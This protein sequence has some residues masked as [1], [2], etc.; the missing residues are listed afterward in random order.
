MNQKGHIVN[1]ALLGI[2]LGYILQPSS[3][4]AMVRTIFEVSV[5]IILGALFPDVD[6]HFGTHRQT[7]H[8]LV[9]L[10]IFLVFPVYFANL[11]WVWLGVL[12]HYVLDF[13]GT[14]RGLALLYPWSRE[15]DF[16]LGVS[17]DSRYA[18]AMMLAITAF[19]L[20]VA[21]ALVHVFPGLVESVI[22]QLPFRPDAVAAQ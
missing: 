7:L 22:A 15:F 20:V 17:V 4:A 11:H 10:W 2:G 5:P 13:L 1:A 8:N 18:D 6:A 21:Y 14:K 3:D 16:P 19:E 12:T 9:V